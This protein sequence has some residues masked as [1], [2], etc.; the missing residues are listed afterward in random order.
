M[1][2]LTINIPDAQLSRVTDA[3]T[4]VHSYDPQSGFTPAQFTRR[5]LIAYVKGVV[6]AHE[7]EL[8]RAQAEQAAAERPG[9]DVT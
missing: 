9:P 3:F 6:R 5:V 4:A 2:Q 8:A 7:I 1:T